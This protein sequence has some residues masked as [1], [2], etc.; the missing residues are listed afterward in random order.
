MASQDDRSSSSQTV[1]SVSTSPRGELLSS[2]FLRKTKFRRKSLST[3]QPEILSGGQAENR[4]MGID[5]KEPMPPPT[6]ERAPPASASASINSKDDSPPPFESTMASE[7]LQ[8]LLPTKG[9]KN[10]SEVPTSS[11]HSMSEDGDS[12][13]LSPQ[14]SRAASPPG[15]DIA[16]STAS[17]P[18]VSSPKVPPKVSSS[19][20]A[21]PMSSFPLS[22]EEL[23]HAK[24]LVL[25]L[26]G[27]GV[28]PEYLVD[29]GVSSEA[30]FRIFTDLNLRLPTNLKLSEE[31]KATAY[32]WGPPP[33]GFSQAAE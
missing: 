4:V 14:L 12:N 11:P 8:S 1:D 23:D 15:S 2:K 19:A 24:T 3:G 29:S 30:I 20:P 9:A 16:S 31:I 18:R 5:A 25:D 22:P 32:S 26:L 21:P 10:D 27:W 17:S 33:D 13:V 6:V 28:D 7:E